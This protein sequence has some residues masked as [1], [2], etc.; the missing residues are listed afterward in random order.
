MTITCISTIFA[1]VYSPL[2]DGYL[3]KKQITLK[4]NAIHHQK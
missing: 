4:F 3:H 1:G 2:T